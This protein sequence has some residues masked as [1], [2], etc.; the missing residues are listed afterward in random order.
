MR[1]LCLFGVFVAFKILVLAGRDIP[2]GVWTPLA[3]F[4]QDAL[5]ALLFGAADF[6]SRRPRFGWILYGA[7]VAYM[8]LNLAVVRVLSTPLTWPMLRAARGPLADSV[9]FYLTASN[10]LLVA[11]LLAVAALL[12]PAAQKLR[13]RWTAVAAVVAVAL[14][15]AGP[16]AARRIETLGLERNPLFALATSALPRTAQLATDAP[17]GRDPSRLWRNSPL[18]S[19]TGRDDLSS[20]RGAAAGRNVIL[21]GLESVAA[22]YLLSYGADLDLTPN[23]SRLA[24]QSILFENAYAAYPESIK[25]LFSVLCSTFPIM[26]TEPE[27]YAGVSRVSVA[28]RLQQ[29]GYRTGLFH[30]GRFRYLGMESIIRNRGYQT[31]EDAGAIE[32]NHES[33]FGVEEFAT[34]RRI[35]SW[36]D[37]DR[38]RRFFVTYL[39]IAGHHPYE[40][41]KRGPFPEP[42]EMGRYRNALLYADA[43]LG[44]LIAGLRQR[45]LE[46]ETLWVIYGDHGEAFGQHAGNFGHTFFLYDENVRVPLLLA[47]PGIVNKQHRVERVASLVDVAPTLLDLVGLDAS[48]SNS[49]GHSLLDPRATMALFF[50]DYSLR[51]VGLRDGDW[52]FIHELDSGHSKLFDLQ[53]DPAEQHDL[54]MQHPARAESYRRHLLGWSRGQGS[55]VRG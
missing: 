36:I 10:L 38:S 39:P 9:F 46:D 19:G 50:T 16:Q 26:D 43:A 7:V 6:A 8:G 24:R 34:V 5:V 30:S 35:L 27:L 45:G 23:L 52:K 49:D 28:E 13:P 29:A 1:A 47:A 41:P 48:P 21:V 42:D 51:L 14:V 4:W 2:L 3:Y 31:L 22:Q 17:P 53:S 25:G 32:G 33:S 55:G 12:P 40:T 44:T 11:L 37:T 54:S 20:Y 15:V 18:P